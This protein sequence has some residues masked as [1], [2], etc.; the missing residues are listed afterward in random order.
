MKRSPLERAL[1]NDGYLPLTKLAGYSGLSVRT[2]RNY[3]TH[4]SRPLPHYR[5]GGKILVRQS[6]YDAWAMAFRTVASDQISGLVADVL[7]GLR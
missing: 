7:E 5:I 2:L 3:L 4:P 1:P 6:D